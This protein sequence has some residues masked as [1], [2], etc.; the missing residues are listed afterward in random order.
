MVKEI[1]IR[2]QIIPTG[3]DK[4]AEEVRD[5]QD[6]NKQV[7]RKASFILRITSRQYATWQDP[8]PGRREELQSIF[9]ALW[10]S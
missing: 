1:S 3:A 8:Y 5:E 6:T 7:G 4:E 9:E 2:N 10:S